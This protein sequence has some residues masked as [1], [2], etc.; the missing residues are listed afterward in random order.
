MNKDMND[1]EVASTSKSK[2]TIKKN[3]YLTDDDFKDLNLTY[4]VSKFNYRMIII[5]NN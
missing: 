4:D 3:Y 5:V 1:N 2:R